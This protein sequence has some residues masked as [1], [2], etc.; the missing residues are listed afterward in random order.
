LSD[1]SDKERDLAARVA[2][3]PLDLFQGKSI[4]WLE[5]FIRITIGGGSTSGSFVAGDMK[6]IAKD[7]TAETGVYVYEDASGQ[8]LY[9]N[10]AAASRS[11]QALPS[12]LRSS[13]RRSLRTRFTSSRWSG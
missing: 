11:R 9:C 6:V 7:L 13:R 5:D 8:W 1:L 3:N 10:G 2:D 4:G 12:V